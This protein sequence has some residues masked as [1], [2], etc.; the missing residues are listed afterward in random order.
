VTS[1]EGVLVASD[2]DGGLHLTPLGSLNADLSPALLHMVTSAV[3]ARVSTVVVDLGSLVAFDD[4]GVHAVRCCR[5]L[6]VT[7]S[8][9]L[10]LRAGGPLGAS[11]LRAS[12][13]VPVA[14]VD[15]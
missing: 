3:R 7:T 6:A 8:T 5:R 10:D 2:A 11:L 12:L 13:A 14:T 4:R 15:A 1:V 9:A